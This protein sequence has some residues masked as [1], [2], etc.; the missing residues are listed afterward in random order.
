MCAAVMS[1]SV[2]STRGVNLE[3]GLL[4]WRRIL[5]AGDRTQLRELRLQCI[6]GFAREIAAYHDGSAAEQL[7]DFALVETES[8]HQILAHGG[9]AGAIGHF[10]AE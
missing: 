10:A 2:W 7:R 8:A 6:R 3:L 4:V 5:D 9:F 1:F